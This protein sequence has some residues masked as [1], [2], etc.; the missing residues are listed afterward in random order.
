MLTLGLVARSSDDEV[1]YQRYYQQWSDICM[2]RLVLHSFILKRLPK[3]F[4]YGT[5][6]ICI[7]KK[8]KPFF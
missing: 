6:K 4:N 8:F 3:D 1:D 5:H 2:L 7:F